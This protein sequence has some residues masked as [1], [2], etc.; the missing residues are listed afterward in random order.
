MNGKD[1]IVFSPGRIGPLEIK[2]RLVRS[3][4]FENAATSE[5]AVSDFLVNLYRDLAQGGVG[6]IITGTA[7]VYPE[8]L[9][10]PFLVR[11]DDDSFIPS[12][13]RIPRAVHEVAPDCRE[14]PPSRNFV[15]SSLRHIGPDRRPSGAF[16]ARRV[17]R[18]DLRSHAE[19]DRNRVAHLRS[20]VFPFHS[21]NRHADRLRQLKAPWELVLGNRIPNSSPPYLATRS[22]GLRTNFF[23]QSATALKQSSPD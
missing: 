14:T 2:N 23:K 12:L 11:A 5:G 20:R 21:A 17:P 13:A 10:P 3:A 18:R 16:H 22:P 9:A 1:S 19:A 4:T 8:A 15:H 6:L 7:G